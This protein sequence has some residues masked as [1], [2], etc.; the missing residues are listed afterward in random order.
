MDRVVRKR[1]KRNKKARVSLNKEIIRIKKRNRFEMIKKNIYFLPLEIK[2]KIYQMAIQ[3]HMYEW[4]FEHM[5]NNRKV[6]KFLTNTPSDYS[7]ENKYSC[8]NL[9][10]DD[11][12]DDNDDN[13]DNNDNN[14]NYHSYYYKHIC[15]R[16]VKKTGQP[17]IRSIYID[18]NIDE[19]IDYREW[20]GDA[21]YYW[22]HDKCRCR[23]CDHV[24]VIGIGNLRLTERAK[25][26]EF[27]EIAWPGW[28]DQW[29][30]ARITKS[31]EEI[32]YEKNIRRTIRRKK[33]EGDLR[34]YILKN[35]EKDICHPMSSF[36]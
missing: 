21:D 2:I 13:N 23:D 31:K 11:N 17:G 15:H 29:F 8:W 5:K 3:K 10:I 24:R 25:Y 4:S 26:P 36:D 35:W 7:D 14:D 19:R 27:S 30:P 1:Q 32:K 33:K 28:S 16:N 20:I 22:Y 18:D 6:L 9:V 34:Y 12:N